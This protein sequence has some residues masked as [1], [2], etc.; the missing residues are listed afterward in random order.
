MA[1]DFEQYRALHRAATVG[2]EVVCRDVVA[3][4][5]DEARTGASAGNAPG[6]AYLAGE[7]TAGRGREGRSWISAA[8]AG[9]YVTFHLIPSHATHAPLLSV[10]GALAV[11]DALQGTCGLA[12][13]LKWPNDVLVG[14]RKLCG[15]LAEAR[16]NM[17]RADVF[18]GIG[19]NLT[20]QPDQIG[21]A[22]V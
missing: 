16:H 9:L 21:R 14:E 19:Q 10:A 11:A 4:T 12:V 18:L 8:E 17:G 22:H 1:F 20:T 3:S 7:Q 5:M 15:V 6:T 2:A 13:D